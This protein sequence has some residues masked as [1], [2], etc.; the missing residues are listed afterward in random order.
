MVTPTFADESEPFTSDIRKGF[1]YPGDMVSFAGQYAYVDGIYDSVYIKPEVEMTLKVTREDG[2]MNGAK[3][4][5][6]YPGETFY[7]NFTGGEFNIN[8]TAPPVTNDYR[9]TFELVD[10]PNGAIDTTSGLCTGTTSFGCASFNIKV[11]SNSPRVATNSWTAK[12][13]AT[14]EILEGY[15]STSN[16]HCIDVEVIIEEQEALFPGDVQVAW[17]FFDDPNNDI[18]WSSYRST[19]GSDPMKANLDLLPTGG[20]YFATGDCIDL[21]PLEEGQFDPSPED[22]NGVEIIF[23]IEGVDSAGSQIILGG[24]PQEDSSAIAHMVSGELSH[25]S[26]YNFIHEEAKFDILNVKMN[27]LNPTVGQKMTL[28]VELRNTGTMA[29]EASLIVKSVINDGIPSKIGMIETEEL[30]IGQSAWFTI[31]LEAFPSATTG[32]YYMIFDNSSSDL[33]YDGSL[34]GDQFNVKVQGESSDNG[35]ALLLAIVGIIA[36][37]LAVLVVVLFK[38]G[39]DNDNS[40]DLFGDGEYEEEGK[41][42]AELPTDSSHPSDLDPE[43]ARAIATFPQWNQAEIQGY[44]DQGWSIEALQDWVKGQ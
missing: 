40:S 11:D 27:P 7:H 15:I 22:I 18:A 26:I 35:M 6:A 19:H 21:W 4:Y 31:E 37:V 14:G 24:G 23:W 28:E 2:V 1:V 9:Y 25:K 34:V 13:G 3:G 33:K 17:K 38:R 8:I 43:M 20:S 42:Y 12:K 32:M 30:A 29:G 16:Y 44:F 36:A 5:I 41:V 10:L 39:Q